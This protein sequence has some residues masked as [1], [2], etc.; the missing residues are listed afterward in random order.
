MIA[1]VRNYVVVMGNDAGKR[2]KCGSCG[3][4]IVVTKGGEGTVTCCGEPMVPKQ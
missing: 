2:L 4:E 1:A 3:A